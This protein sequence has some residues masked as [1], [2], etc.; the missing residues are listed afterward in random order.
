M[1][2]R[3]ITFDVGGTLI[4]PW[5]SVGHVYAEVAARFG[6]SGIAPEWLTENFRRAWKAQIRFDYTRE[7]WFAIVRETFGEHAAELPSE[8]YPAVFNRFATADTWRIYDDVLPALET[9]TARGVKLGIISNWDERLRPLLADLQLARHFS[10]LVISCETGA[11]KPDARLFAR[12]ARELGVAPGELLHVGDNLAMDMHGAEGFGAV[13]RQ[14]VR[15]KRVTDA[16]QIGSLAELR[17]LAD[18]N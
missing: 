11:T 2:I 4:E 18:G 3:A 13:G 6:V 10:S 12:A 8:F 7:S 9:L 14:V 5:P 16:W 15:H 1:R 17:G